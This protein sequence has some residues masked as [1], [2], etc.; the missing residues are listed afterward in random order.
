[1]AQEVIHSMRNKVGKR[2]LMAM[3][4]DL[5]KAYDRLSWSFIHDTLLEAKIPIPLVQIIMECIITARMNVFWNG[6]LTEEFFPSRGIRQGDQFRL[7]F[8]CSA[9]RDLT[10]VLTRCEYGEV[11]SSSSIL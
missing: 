7:I 10:M 1:M 6:E 2:G 8:L 9:L 5:E 4:A 3:K 11:E